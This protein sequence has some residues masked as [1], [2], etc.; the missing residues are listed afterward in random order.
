MF[1]HTQAK[2]FLF[3]RSIA[4]TGTEAVVQKSPDSDKYYRMNEKQVALDAN[5]PS[6]G[7]GC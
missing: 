2:T 1:L 4:Q 3:F 5:E 6:D 7:Y